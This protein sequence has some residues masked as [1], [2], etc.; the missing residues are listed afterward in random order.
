MIVLLLACS[1]PAELVSASSAVSLHLLS[2]LLC[3]S[4][5]AWVSPAGS[6]TGAG[7]LAEAKAVV[8][9]GVGEQDCP[10]SRRRFQTHWERICQNSC[11]Q[12][13]WEH[14]RSGSCSPSSSAKT[15]SNDPRCKYKSSRS[16]AVIAGGTTDITRRS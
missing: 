12:E 13:V 1:A 11:P 2:S 5:R 14:Q 8:R 15:V 4:A 16:L 7:A 10:N 3:H 9:S 6:L